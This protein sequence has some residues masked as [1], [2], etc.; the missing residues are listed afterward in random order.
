MAK[1]WQKNDITYLKRYSS[2][3]TAEEL[4]RRF[5]TTT[6]EVRD[7]LDKLGIAAKGQTAAQDPVVGLFS[8]A[9]ELVHEKEWQKARKVFAKVVEESDQNE[10]TGRAQ[11]YLTICQEQLGENT[12]EDVDDPFLEAVVLKNQGRLEEALEQAEKG[13]GKDDR[14][15]YLQASI[16]S[17]LEQGDEAE[18]ALRKAVELNPRNRIYAFHD[19]DFDHL[20]NSE[21]HAHL[22]EVA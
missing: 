14:F 6:E 1:S 13:S 22:F 3:K 17:L 7:Q 19:P 8:E 16:H 5:D 15:V 4:A 21:E 10:I 18:K 2:T 12:P 11:Q 9:L 20:R